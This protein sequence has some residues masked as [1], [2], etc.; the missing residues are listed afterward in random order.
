MR[1]TKDIQTTL[2]RALAGQRLT[3][4]DCTAL[5]QS[6]D[7]ARIGFAADEI[8]KRWHADDV[9]TYIIDRNI[10]YTNVCNVVCTF[11]AFYR[12]PGAPDTYVQTV[13][14]IGERIDEMIRLG[15]TGVLMQGGLHPDY[16]IEWYENLLR[17]LHGRYPQ[18]QLHCFSPP[19]IHNI[20]LISK[21]SYEDVLA[22]LKDAGLYSLPGGG[23]EI[24]DDEVRKRVSTKC[25]TEEWLG[26]MRAA[27]LVGLRST[28]TMMFGIGDTLV[29]RV[30]H[31]ERI[32]NL[33]DETGGFT[34]FIPWTFQRENTA[35]GRRIKDEPTG[36]DY[37]KMLAVSRL[38]LDN[39]ENFQSSWLTQGLRLGQVALRFGANDMGSTMI[40]ENVVSAAGAHNQADEKML[41]YLIREA[42]F[43][44]Q[45]RDILYA[46]VNRDESLQTDASDS[47]PLRELTVMIAD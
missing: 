36:V 2:D 45:Q 17:E 19:E 9:V 38:F 41:R 25:T 24:L 4:D 22:R 7:I 44:P 21:L 10:N 40:E 35:L 26:V 42:G 46:R 6:H 5:L 27:H 20:H 1:E 11:C 43:T 13:D 18:V 37:L 47:A 23:G 33:Q 15:G 8:R 16:G 12:R 28:A 29:H 34:A 30:R 39:I 31:L 14:Q 32:R 3:A